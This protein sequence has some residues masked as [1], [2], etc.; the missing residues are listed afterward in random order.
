MSKALETMAESLSDIVQS[1]RIE[2][3]FHAGF[4]RHIRPHRLVSAQVS[5][6][7]Q[8]EIW[9]IDD[10]IGRGTFGIVRL[11]K[12]RHPGSTA[13]SQVRV[14]KEVGKTVKSGARWDY[15]K[16]LEAMVKFSGA[17]VSI[18]NL[19]SIPFNLFQKV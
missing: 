18:P 3:T 14:V 6:V 1:L 4:V 19:I 9:D 16:E 17:H 10:T 2:T 12:R 8:E 5:G 15:M 7:E 11:E 13:S